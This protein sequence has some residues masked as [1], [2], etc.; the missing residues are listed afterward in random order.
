MHQRGIDP[1]TAVDPEAEG[2]QH[3]GQECGGN[4]HDD[5]AKRYE[6]K[7]ERDLSQSAMSFLT[8]YKAP[9]REVVTLQASGLKSAENLFYHVAIETGIPGKTMT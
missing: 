7:S 4:G 8:C 1:G 2:H 5:T 9:G 6:Q 3:Q